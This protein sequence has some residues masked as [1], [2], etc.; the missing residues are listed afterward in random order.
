[1]ALSY[2]NAIERMAA[3]SPSLDYPTNFIAWAEVVTDTLCAIYQADYEE[4]TEMLYEAVK[5]HQDYEPEEDA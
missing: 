3:A 2:E 1:M 4:T 5:E